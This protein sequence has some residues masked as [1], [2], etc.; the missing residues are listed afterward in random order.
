MI[1]AYVQLEI[2]AILKNQIETCNIF[3]DINSCSD[4][5]NEIWTSRSGYKIMGDRVSVCHVL[6]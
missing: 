5:Q 4:S 3:N 1:I 2:N 6:K